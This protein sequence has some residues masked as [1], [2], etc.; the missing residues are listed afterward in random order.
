MS[1]MLPEPARVDILL[2]DDDQSNLLALESVL[3]ASD[4][5]LIRASSGDEA[6]Q[7]LLRHNVAVIL[8][9]VRMPGISGLE[10]AELIRGRKQSRDIPI[11]FLT[12]YEGTDSEDL[13]RGY[14]LGAV[15]YIIKPLDPDALKAKVNVFVDLFKKT[16]QVKQ[17]AAMLH[18]KNIQLENANFQR[19]GKLVD[20][21]QLLISQREPDRLLQV[22]C[23]AARDIVGAEYGCVRIDEGTGEPV[24]HLA[25]ND[26]EL[27]AGLA[28]DIEQISRSIS[29]VASAKL[30][31]RRISRVE[32]GSSAAQPLLNR[33]A[34]NSLL[35]APIPLL[36]P[37]TGWLYLSGKIDSD[38]FSEADE[39]LAMTLT[40]QLA[41]AYE[42]ARLYADT[43]RYAAELLAEV[44]ERKHAQEEKERLLV[45]EK[46]ARLEAEQAQ[47][48]SAQLLIREKD[49]RAQAEAAN[50]L[51]DDFLATVSHELRT[52]LNSILGWVQLMLTGRFDEAQSM[53]ALRTIE[54]N[55]KALAQI[56]EDLLDV[57]RIISGQLRL[58]VKPLELGPVIATAFD[59][60]RPGVDAKNIRLKASLDDSVG[61]ILGDPNRIQQV[62]WNLLSNATKF[63]PSG[64]EVEVKLDRVQANARI[65]VA[66]SGEGI[67]KEF[68]PHVFERF[69][70]ADSSFARVHGGLGLGLA[71]VR[72]L[73]EM[74]GGA[75]GADSPGPGK[76]AVF[77]VSF[78][79]LNGESRVPS[80]SKRKADEFVS[81]IEDPQNLAGL[82]VLIVD[83][84]PDTRDVLVAILEQRGAEVI[85]SATADDA[86][87]RLCEASNGSIP[88]VL[89]SDIG[90]PGE[91][92]LG[93]I[94]R[95]RALKPEQGGR[96]PAVA[97][98]AY[99][100]AEDRARVLAA[101][102]QRHVTKPVEP[103]VLAIMVASLARGAKL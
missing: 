24:R 62:V 67:S 27:C 103:S 43:R 64:G 58:D 19:L 98:T 68:L 100:R 8:L 30:Q 65:T 22:F 69:T 77:T 48:V 86:L 34:L 73:V 87:M 88:D 102:Y 36:K 89:V 20:L 9:D 83:D 71:I 55:T 33:P 46:A 80:R 79:L 25:A 3:Q 53:R 1:A 101:G 17:Q 10:T 60:V 40:G 92:G 49:A 42:N 26:P 96:I 31:A 2:V 29:S 91:D 61:A 97:L 4:R 18:E 90:L 39:R 6:L 21:G 82:R 78:P 93:L 63:T 59:A 44:T 56:I 66:D 37:A 7:Y 47:L 38:S 94:S 45:S 85:A 99:A 35:A 32:N 50:R 95:V 81:E 41:A 12:A 74:H 75:V 52:P 11:I 70:Q 51:K 72:H 14:S 28:D 57:S 76:G 84:E 15:D 16:E 13:S 23:K 54:R 5:N